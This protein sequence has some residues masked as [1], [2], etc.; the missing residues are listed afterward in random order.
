MKRVACYRFELFG[1]SEGNP[2]IQYSTIDEFENDKIYD[3][4]RNSSY[5]K[6]KNVLS[7]EPKCK[8]KCNK[9]DYKN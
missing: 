5:K 3:G 2:L 9:I 1:C 7:N 6:E 4:I 8:F